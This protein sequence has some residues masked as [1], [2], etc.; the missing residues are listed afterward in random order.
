MDESCTR[1]HSTWTWSTQLGEHKESNRGAK[2][3]PTY[4]PTR[5]KLTMEFVRCRCGDSFASAIV[6]GYTGKHDVAA[7]MKLANAVGA[8]TA[9]KQGAGRNVASFD[10]VR[11]LLRESRNGEG[12]YQR[13]LALKALDILDGRRCAVQHPSR[14]GW[15]IN[16]FGA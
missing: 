10:A 12:A 7:T 11:I 1:M 16:A 9:T 13:E 15:S 3:N 4:L 14:G 6:M 2:C 8:A 5:N